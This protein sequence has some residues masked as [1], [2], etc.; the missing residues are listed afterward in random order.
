ML[1]VLSDK[2][3]LGIY[4]RGYAFCCSIVESIRPE[5]KWLAGRCIVTLTG[6]QSGGRHCGDAKAVGKGCRRTE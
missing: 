2:T 5:W 6:V 1:F 4:T 3:P